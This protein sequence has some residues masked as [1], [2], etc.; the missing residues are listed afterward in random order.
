MTDF[1]YGTR[2]HAEALTDGRH[3]G[4]A[5]GLQWLTYAHLPPALQRYS[6]PFY[7]AAE[8]ILTE[9]ET[10]SPELINAITLLRQAKDE[11]VRAGIRNDIGRAGSVLRPQTVVEPPKLSTQTS[12]TIGTAPVPFANL[13]A[14][15][16]PLDPPTQ[17]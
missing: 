16:H 11:A 7:V 4:I 3:R 5:D 9:I 10:D 15:L 12:R 14:S 17:D 8:G 2:E 6:R 13:D 1:D